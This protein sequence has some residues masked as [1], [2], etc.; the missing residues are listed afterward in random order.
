MLQREHVSH[1]VNEITEPFKAKHRLQGPTPS[2]RNS[3]SISRR[4]K[5]YIASTKWI[6]CSH[7]RVSHA[8]NSQN[9]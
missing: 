4:Q 1:L 9:A 2:E 5:G 3:V 7:K 6:R 8:I